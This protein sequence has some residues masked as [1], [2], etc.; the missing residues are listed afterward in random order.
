MEAAFFALTYAW[1]NLRRGGM[2]SLFAAFCVAVGVAAVVG[3][4]L[5]ALNIS[6]AVDRAPKEANGGD[7]AVDPITT[8]FQSSDIAKVEELRRQGRIAAYTITLSSN[9]K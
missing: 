2:R 8:P 3:M 5:L 9:A 4:Q 1:R 6:A 7:I